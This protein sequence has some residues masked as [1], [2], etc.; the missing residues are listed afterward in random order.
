[1]IKMKT[2]GELLKEARL[3]KNYTRAGLGAESHIKASFIQAIERGDWEDLPEFAVVTGFVKSLSH[4]LD[5]DERLVVSTLRRDY[6]P[7][8]SAP[9]SGKMRSAKEISKKFYWRPRLTFIV[10]VGVVLIIVLAY[11]G[12]QYRKFNLP[13]S[14]VLNSPTQNE[15]LHNYT[16][17][18]SGRTD[19]DATVAVDGQ[20]VI[21][22]SNGN[23]TATVDVA[24]NTTMIKIIATSRSGKQTIVWRT[25]SVRL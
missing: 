10:G 6:P 14:L 22:D 5:V 16:L 2:A 20:S 15:V 13:P 9:A 4:F 21:V 3:K 12:F 24:K 25:I 11:L 1:M 19:S 17:E 8:L 23:F 7:E 18:V